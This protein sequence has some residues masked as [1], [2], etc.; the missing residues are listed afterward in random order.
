M[1]R[2]T[3]AGDD[4]YPNNPFASQPLQY[5]IG[6]LGLEAHRTKVPAL[7][8]LQFTYLTSTLHRGGDRFRSFKSAYIRSTLGNSQ[9]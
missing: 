7:S 9:F 2:R 3:K 8:A 6:T 1:L 5:S 4:R